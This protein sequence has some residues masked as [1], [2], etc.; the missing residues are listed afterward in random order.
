MGGRLARRCGREIDQRHSWPSVPRGHCTYSPVSAV[1]ASMRVALTTGPATAATHLDAG[2]VR[3]QIPY[4][5]DV[6]REI[7]VEW[8]VRFCPG[9]NGICE[10]DA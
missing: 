2:G 4:Y 7:T 5:R 1:L 8:N 6:V 10:S 3:Q 9:P